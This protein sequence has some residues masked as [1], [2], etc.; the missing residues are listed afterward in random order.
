MKRRM[1]W[2]FLLPAVLMAFSGATCREGLNGKDAIDAQKKGMISGMG[3][4]VIREET[5]STEGED[6]HVAMHPFEDTLVFASTAYSKNSDLFYKK[7]GSRQR[8]QLTFHKGSDVWPTFNPEGD[9]LVFTSDRGGHW[10]LYMIS[11]PPRPDEKPEK[12][13]PSDTTKVHASWSQDGHSIVY[14]EYDEIAGDW[15]LKILDLGGGD[16]ETGEFAVSETLIREDNLYGIFPEWC[17]RQ[18]DNRIVFQRARRRGGHLYGIWTINADGSGLTRVVDSTDYATI[19]PSWHPTLD[20][21][22]YATV[23]VDEYEKSKG[24]RGVV[25]AEDIWVINVDGTGE[26]RITDTARIADW[27]PIFSRPFGRRIFFTSELANRI[28]LWSKDYHPTR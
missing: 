13:A 25:R 18:G 15:R 26:T 28:N 14:S 2:L 9:L 10:D 27:G 24:T 5:T 3:P 7:I 22:V 23:A 4:G 20:K 21:I 17:P 11:F 19:N 1:L 8:R 12:L 16:P 6:F